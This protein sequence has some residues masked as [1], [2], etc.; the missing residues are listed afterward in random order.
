MARSNREKLIDLIDRFAPE[1]KAAFL[2]AIDDITSSADLGR[3]VRQ[4]EAGN[5]EGALRAV[6]LDPA[7]FRPLDIAMARAYDAGGTFGASTM[8]AFRDGEGQRLVIRFDARNPRAEDWIATRSSELVTEI[9]Q[10]QRTAIRAALTEGLKAGQNPR[11]V[12]LDIVGRIDPKTGKRT[13]GVVGLTSQQEE[14]AR[15]YRAELL[16]G[17]PARMRNALTRALRDKR[18]DGQVLKA[19]EAGAPLDRS[20][21][22]TLV[23]R[24]RAS[25]LRF[26]GEAIGRTEALTTL[27]AAQD[28]AYQQAVDKGAVDRSA[29]TKIWRDSG[30]SR[31]RHTH[32]VM[33]GQKVRFD[34]SFES[35]S[36]ARLKFPGDPAAPAAEIIHCRC[37]LEMKVDF[38]KGVR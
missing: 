27:H 15:N 36:G 21:A 10:D 16:S 23:T 12:A 13:G 35:P 34:Q 33:H 3:I 4:I 6:N 14:F 7:A 19:I 18:F 37:Y 22:D 29:L 38:L 5:I 17:D 2:E 11:Q 24:Y 20:T 28:E 26:R 31:V 8:P 1:L 9:V 25:L 32:R 30:D